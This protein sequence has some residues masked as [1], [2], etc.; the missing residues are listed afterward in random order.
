M[1]YE[2]KYYKDGRLQR[3]RVRVAGFYYHM[4]LISCGPHAA[5]KAEDCD[6]RCPT[7][8]A[9]SGRSYRGQGGEVRTMGRSYQWTSRSG[10]IIMDRHSHQIICQI[11][12][13]TPVSYRDTLPSGF[14]QVKHWLLIWVDKISIASPASRPRA[15]NLHIPPS[16]AAAKDP[17]SLRQ[18]T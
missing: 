10:W 14:E 7:P 9:V 12:A 15:I 8:R 6:W 3:Q 18:S 16:P 4:R 2:G 11:L 5:S 1:P 13:S 17:S